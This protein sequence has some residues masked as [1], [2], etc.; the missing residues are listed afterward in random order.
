MTPQDLITLVGNSTWPAA[1][2]LVSW[3]VARPFAQ[4]IATWIDHKLNNG[5]GGET[6]VKKKLNDI[7]RTTEAIAGNHLHE[8]SETLNRMEQ[9]QMRMEGKLDDIKTGVEVVKVKINGK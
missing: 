2:V 8:I 5:S 3:F 4:P 6:Q 7:S 9:G 1:V